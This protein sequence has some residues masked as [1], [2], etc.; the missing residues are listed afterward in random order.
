M[1]RRRNVFI[2]FLGVLFTFGCVAIL[3]LAGAGGVLIWQAAGS[4][5]DYKNLA[6]YTPAL[7]TRV[8]AGDGSLPDEFAREPPVVVP[9][10]AMPDR[11]IKAFLWALQKI[12]C[13]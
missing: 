2:R 6:D 3:V 8:H 5:P 4:L 7:M 11:L 9:V 13:Q 1:R 10:S 12:F